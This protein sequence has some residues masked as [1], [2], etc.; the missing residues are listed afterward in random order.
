MVALLGPSGS[1]KTT[2]LR[3]IAGLEPVTTGT[4]KFGD[5]DV[6]NVR[7]QDRNIGFCFQSYALFQ[8]MTV[9]GN[10]AFG[11]R[12]RGESKADQDRCVATLLDMI[13]LPDVWDRYPKQ[14]SVGQRQRVS[15]ARAL[16]LRPQ[17]LLLD[18]PFGALDAMVRG[19]LRDQ[20][21]DLLKQLWIT[22]ILVTHDQSEAFELAD[23]V[24]VL[25]KGRVEQVGRP[26]EIIRSPMTPFVTNFI[27]EVAQLPADSV[28]PRRMNFRTN[29]PY[30]L[31]RP[32][33]VEVFTTPPEGRP[34][35]GAL[36]EERITLGST[37]RFRFVFDDETSAE[38]VFSRNEDPGC[39]VRDRVYIHVAP[40]TMMG[41]TVEEISYTLT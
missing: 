2:L 10:I 27:G 15:L 13:Q 22:T 34:S 4:V 40:L 20:T 33:D 7:V 8:H 16:A 3:M 18:E 17:L 39:E 31:V 9:A 38:V 24:V 36:V 41:A 1:G 12:L 35:V 6:T 28:L 14:L 25:N 19:T 32:G 11:P 37:I 26:E 29:K 23:Q 21:R 5:T 30:A